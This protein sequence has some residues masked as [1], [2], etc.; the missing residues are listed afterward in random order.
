MPLVVEAIFVLVLFGRPKL[1]EQSVVVAVIGAEKL[2]LLLLRCSL[3][4]EVVSFLF[5]GVVH[6][7][8]GA[9]MLPPRGY[10]V[11]IFFFLNEWQNSC[12]GS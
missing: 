1:K 12:L 3:F 8:V 11:V 9:P 5:L 6:L 7:G 2:L 4:G 10:G